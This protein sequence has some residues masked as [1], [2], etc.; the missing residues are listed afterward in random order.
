MIQ[1]SC[2]LLVPGDPPQPC[3]ASFVRRPAPQSCCNNMYGKK[4]LLGRGRGKYEQNLLITCNML[5]TRIIYQQGTVPALRSS[6]GN[7][8]WSSGTHKATVPI[9]TLSRAAVRH[10]GWALN[11]KTKEEAGEPAGET[12]GEGGS[13]PPVKGSRGRLGVCCVIVFILEHCK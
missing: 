10:L 9:A 8:P 3:K 7:H 1:K 4:S 2:S 11:D 6:G 5:V 13:P 12:S